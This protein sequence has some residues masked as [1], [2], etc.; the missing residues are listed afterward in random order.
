MKDE[1]LY[2]FGVQPLDYLQRMDEKRGYC[3]PKKTEKEQQRK[4][5]KLHKNALLS[6]FPFAI[7]VVVVCCC[8]YCLT[9]LLP[10][11]IFVRK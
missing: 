7:E 9:V 3:T 1:I 11:C 2:W 10:Q 4:G 6:C 5:E 8:Y